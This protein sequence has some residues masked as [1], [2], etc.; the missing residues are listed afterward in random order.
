MKLRLLVL[1]VL[2]FAIAATLAL[3]GGGWRWNASQR[4]H[5]PYLIAGWSWG[6][7]WTW[8]GD[9]PGLRGRESAQ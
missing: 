6:D 7:G 2:A 3:G 8:G 5:A 4:G 1:L 9:A